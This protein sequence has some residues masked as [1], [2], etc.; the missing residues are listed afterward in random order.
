MQI[1][2][3]DPRGGGSHWVLLLTDMSCEQD[4]QALIYDS[5]HYNRVS[6]HIEKVIAQLMSPSKN[7]IQVRWM[8]SD[9]QRNSMDCG[10]YAIAN[11]VAIAFGLDPIRIT[12]DKNLIRMH[13][14]ECI[15]NAKFSPFPTRR[16]SRRHAT[17][18]YHS[19]FIL[20]EC[21]CK[22]PASDALANVSTLTVLN[23]TLKSPGL[24]S[25]SF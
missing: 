9:R 10:V 15:K 16:S 2:N 18:S 17:V 22:I 11:M 13:L 8:E 23:A 24:V 4:T 12:F 19:I 21:T 25:I 1:V 20:L 5:A 3:L 7:L 6:A 14:L